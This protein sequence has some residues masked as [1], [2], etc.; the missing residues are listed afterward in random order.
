[1]PLE[2]SRAAHSCYLARMM[3]LDYPIPALKALLSTNSCPEAP[4]SSQKT[5][6]IL[7]DFVILD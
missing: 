2:K 6:G 4:E 5:L 1:M 3:K 7:C